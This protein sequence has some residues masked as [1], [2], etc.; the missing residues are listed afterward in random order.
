MKAQQPMY[1]AVVLALLAGSAAAQNVVATPTET[2]VGNNGSSLTLTSAQ[3]STWREVCESPK[4]LTWAESTVPAAMP[5]KG[6]KAVGVPAAPPVM[7]LAVTPVLD[8]HGKQ[9]VDSEGHP[10]FRAATEPEG[11]RVQVASA[12]QDETSHKVR[13]AKVHAKTQVTTVGLVASGKQESDAMKTG[14]TTSGSL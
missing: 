6:A 8:A 5:L 13:P 11:A 2:A 10:M 4:T 7:V 14:G 1:V 9:V 3:P 12:V